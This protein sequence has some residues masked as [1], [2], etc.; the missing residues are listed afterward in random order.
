MVAQR[1]RMVLVQT[2]VA[3]AWQPQSRA[4][5]AAADGHPGAW[6]DMPADAAFRKLLG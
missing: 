2:A 5:F 1:T 6:T 3:Q 4:G